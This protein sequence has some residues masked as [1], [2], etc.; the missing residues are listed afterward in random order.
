MIREYDE[1]III[2]FRRYAQRS[3]FSNSYVVW[4][5]AICHPFEYGEQRWQIKGREHS[6]KPEETRRR[7]THRITKTGRERSRVESAF[8]CH[9]MMW[10]TMQG[11]SLLI[12]FTIWFTMT[13]QICRNI[14][15]SVKYVWCLKSMTVSV[16][17]WK[18]Q[19]PGNKS[20]PKFALSKL[21]FSK[22][23]K[24]WMSIFRLSLKQ[25]CRCWRI[26]V[27]VIEVHW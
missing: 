6:S 21:L 24:K 7:W 11:D 18:G 27:I 8:Q 14:P 4:F 5:K 9:D 3:T 22:I 19:Y 2:W 12:W 16:L 26:Q 10:F 15:W 13:G 1:Q 20:L 17:M 25:R 23:S